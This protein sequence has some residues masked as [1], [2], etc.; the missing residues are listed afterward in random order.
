MASDFVLT[1]VQGALVTILL[2]SGPAIIAALVIGLV[3]G[4]AQALT[5]IQDQTLP[6]AV[7]LVAVMLV[8]L[9]LGPV[10]GQQ[11]VEH[12]STALDEFPSVTR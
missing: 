10:L 12:A 6:Q 1:K 9:F 7:K 2:V 8:I 5:Q 11:I 3:V 4:L